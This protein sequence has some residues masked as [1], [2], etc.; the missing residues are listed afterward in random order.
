[1]TQRSCTQSVLRGLRD[2]NFFRSYR[3][4]EVLYSIWTGYTRLV[5]KLP[6]FYGPA[7]RSAA[8]AS[9]WSDRISCY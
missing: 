3:K 7:D 8:T 1:M 6:D 9:H 2:S 5:C 4:E